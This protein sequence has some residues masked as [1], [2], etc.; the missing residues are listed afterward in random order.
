MS[1]VRRRPKGTEPRRRPEDPDIIAVLDQISILTPRE[2]ELATVF[3]QLVEREQFEVDE[4]MDLDQLAIRAAAELE[5]VHGGKA[6]A[7]A[8]SGWLLEQEGVV[9]LYVDDEELARLL[10]IA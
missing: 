10:E 7:A 8:L 3:R 6:R 4:G 9:D 1:N 5:A 2:R